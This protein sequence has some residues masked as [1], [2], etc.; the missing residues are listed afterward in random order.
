M[1]I[2]ILTGLCKKALQTDTLSVRKNRST[3]IKFTSILQLIL[4]VSCKGIIKEAFGP[5]SKNVIIN[6][7]DTKVLFCTE[8]YNADM[9]SVTYYVEFKLIENGRD[10]IHLGTG[11][12]GD[13]TWKNDLQLKRIGNFY[14]L[15]VK[16]YSY[17]KLLFTN[18]NKSKKADTTLSPL[19]L[20]YDNI[21]KSQ[22]DDIPAWVY[23]GSSK[24]DST[25]Q[26]KI[27]VTY[28]YRIG[29]YQP[30]KFYNQ[31]IKYEIDT[32]TGK[33][34]TKKIFERQQK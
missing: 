17:L 34:Q 33:L 30:W 13:T 10:T 22:T 27:F 18:M 15:P 29:N 2:F 14:L 11:S 1:D 32:I 31:T 5:N 28:E 9:H 26:N 3:L 8:T 16:E 19:N 7:S 4:F 25:I 23:T 12:Y 6:L 21:W 20:R 24:L